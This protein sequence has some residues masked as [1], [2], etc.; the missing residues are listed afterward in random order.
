M[1]EG[2]GLR[3]GG[4]WGR[5]GRLDVGGRG[6]VRQEM[7]FLAYGAA[8]VVEGLAN[9]GWVIISFVGILRAWDGLD[10]VSH[11]SRLAYVT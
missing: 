10:K 7:D 8:E 1:I 2:F 9:I 6:G 3:F 4:R 11:G 5:E